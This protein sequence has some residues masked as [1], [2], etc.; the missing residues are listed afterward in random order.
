[1]S[2]DDHGACGDG[3]PSPDLADRWMAWA[4]VVAD[5]VVTETTR[6]THLDAAARAASDAA[7]RR[8]W[9]LLAGRL[10]LRWNPYVPAEEPWR[11]L[12]PHQLPAYDWRNRYPTS[13]SFAGDGAWQVEIEHLP[14]PDLAT[15]E[16]LH[17]VL[18]GPV[19]VGEWLAHGGWR[20]SE[21]DTA[22]RCL[23]ALARL[24]DP[25]IDLRFVMIREAWVAL[26]DVMSPSG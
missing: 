19:P 11:R 13:D 7:T 21:V 9:L 2:T 14:V 10:L 26:S 17:P 18:A 3:R 5:P 22:L 25:L 15:A 23:W 20:W 8:A 16:I 12:L 4:A 1:M 24:D 6:R